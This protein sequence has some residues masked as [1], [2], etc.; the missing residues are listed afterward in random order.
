M[1]KDETLR[2]LAILKAAYPH[3]YNGMTKS[4]A[5]GIV[6]V[7]YMQFASIP[8]DIVLMAVQKVISTS[9]FP[10][11]ISEVKNKIQ[12]VHWEAYEA[13]SD[14]YG[15]KQLSED[16]KKQ[17]KRIYE[18]TQ[19]YKYIKASEPTVRDMVANSQMLMLGEGG[20]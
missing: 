9:K 16:A 8:V 15:S 1:T 10:P 4:E 17:Y 18:I 11:A 13:L 7:W 6:A 2:V 5:H 20:S 3:S 12:A 14:S 19:P